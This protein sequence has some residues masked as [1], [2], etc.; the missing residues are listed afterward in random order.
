MA[1]RGLKP[2]DSDEALFT[3]AQ[4]NK[5]RGVWAA[6]EEELP[7]GSMQQFARDILLALRRSCPW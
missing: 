6:P 4:L 5:A 1:Y 3:T 2:K 7:C